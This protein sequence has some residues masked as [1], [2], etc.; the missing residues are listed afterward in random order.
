[1]N[2]LQVRNNLAHMMAEDPLGI[3]DPLTHEGVDHESLDMVNPVDNF[4]C[5]WMDNYV[6]IY[7]SDNDLKFKIKYED[8]TEGEIA[9]EVVA[10]INHLQ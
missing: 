10:I 1:M 9:S 6:E 7:D 4:R 5:N 2:F 8:R 3:N